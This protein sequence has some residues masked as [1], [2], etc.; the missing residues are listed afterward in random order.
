[1]DNQ[2]PLDKFGRFIVE[3]LRDKGIHYANGLLNDYWKAPTLKVIQT[4]LGK[5]SD[6]QKKALQTAFTATIDSAIHDF[7]FALQDQADIKHGIQIIIDGKNIVKLSD[8]IHGEAYSDN[9]WYAKYS[10]FNTV[11]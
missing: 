2:N 7:L 1:M 10:S 8:G 5:L 4:E 6:K 11:D 3:N 9:G